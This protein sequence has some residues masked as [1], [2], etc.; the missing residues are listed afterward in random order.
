M[1]RG[2]KTDIPIGTKFGTLEVLE[3]VYE[4]GLSKLKVKC[5]CGTIETKRKWPIKAGRVK[6]CLKCTEIIRRNNQKRGYKDIDGTLL[7]RIRRNAKSRRIRVNVDG[8]F[9][10]NLFVKQ[11]GKCALSGINISIVKSDKR[12]TCSASLDR[13]DS[14]KGYTKENVQWVHKD[15]NRIKQHFNQEKF[16][17]W[18][19]LVSNHSKC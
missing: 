2:V 6:E 5:D 9:L 3:N 7:G 17:E 4:Q 12:H 10:Y 18:C 15:I 11:Q 1:P 19:R 14:K 16:I 8:K 13:I